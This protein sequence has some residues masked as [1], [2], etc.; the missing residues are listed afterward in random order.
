[1]LP[2]CVR[3]Q[4]RR[5]PEALRHPGSARGVLDMRAPVAVE[6]RALGS[7]GGA[8]S[9]GGGALKRRVEKRRVRRRQRIAD[10]DR[11]RRRDMG[12]ARAH[13]LWGW[14]IGPSQSGRKS[15]MTSWVDGADWAAAYQRTTG[16]PARFLGFEDRR[17]VVEVEV[18]PVIEIREVQLR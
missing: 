3:H 10:R 5:T 2:Q 11:N 15:A 1:M 9:D 13:A 14:F 4:N 8:R 17:A 16:L 7:R 18:S 12:H 6:A